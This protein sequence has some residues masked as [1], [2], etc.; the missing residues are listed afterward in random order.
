MM[1][2]KAKGARHR[3]PMKLKHEISYF[4]FG[5]RESALPKSV[6]RK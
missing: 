5:R 6:T 4:F 3:V 1:R 2:Q